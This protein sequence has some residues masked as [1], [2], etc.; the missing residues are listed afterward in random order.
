MPEFFD[1][2][3]S[4]CREYPTDWWY[5][6]QDKNS[7][8]NAASALRICGTCPVREKCLSYALVNETHGIWGGMREA[9]RELERRRRNIQLSPEAFAS[10]SASTRRI[11]TRLNKLDTTEQEWLYS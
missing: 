1:T 8:R 3:Q 10:I 2:S 4:A 5:P 9:E 11:Y 7:M 6:N